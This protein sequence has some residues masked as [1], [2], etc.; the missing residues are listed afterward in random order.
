M[1]IW[2]K[3]Q[4]EGTSVSVFRRTFESSL[5]EI[6]NDLISGKK[7]LR[8]LEGLHG[9]HQLDD[10]FDWNNLKAYDLENWNLKLKFEVWF[11][12][13]LNW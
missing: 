10:E 1:E 12:F 11:I 7:L 3:N 8:K 2:N 4:F 13:S 6:L 9:M 5:K